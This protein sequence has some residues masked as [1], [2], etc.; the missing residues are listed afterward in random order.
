MRQRI[1]YI[2]YLTDYKQT[3]AEFFNSETTRGEIR[4]YTR[5]TKIPAMFWQFKSK[6]AAKLVGDKLGKRFTIEPFPEQKQKQSHA[7]AKTEKQ[8]AVISSLKSVSQLRKVTHF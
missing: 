6:K 8:M 4:S 1:H 2:I 7:T 3:L 5:M